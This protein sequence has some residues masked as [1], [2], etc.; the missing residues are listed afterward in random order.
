MKRTELGC[1][2]AFGVRGLLGE[3]YGGRLIPADAVY[4]WDGDYYPD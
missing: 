4:F 2:P 3:R 1:V